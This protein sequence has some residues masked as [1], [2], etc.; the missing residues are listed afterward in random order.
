[1]TNNSF[2]LKDLWEK[3]IISIKGSQEIGIEIIDTFFIDAK[4][5]EANEN[6]VIILTEDIIRK[7]ILDSKK[8]I[9]KA[10]LQEILDTTKDF[11]LEIYIESQFKTEK[12][13][14][15][16]EIPILKEFDGQTIMPHMTFDNFV[17]GDFNR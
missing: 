6:K 8:D 1:M 9:I 7:S 13:G 16:I 14:D 5:Y 2:Y 15:T 17:V 4:I 10:H 12:L 3:T 11:I